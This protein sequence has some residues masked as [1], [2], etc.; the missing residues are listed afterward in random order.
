M[1]LTGD[2]ILD[3]LRTELGLDTKNIVGS[4]PLFSSGI[5]N[6]FSLVTLL[7][8]LETRGGFRIPP[9][10]ITLENFDSIDRILAY[11]GRL[12]KTGSGAEA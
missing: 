8:Y 2:D 6:S 5:I 4:T 10:D 12:I 3:A 1:D 9:M 7:L 11:V